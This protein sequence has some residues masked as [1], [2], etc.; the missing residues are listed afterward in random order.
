MRILA[1]YLSEALLHR[2]DVAH[3]CYDD[4]IRQHPDPNVKPPFGWLESGLLSGDDERASPRDFQ[5]E[6][7]K[8]EK[9]GSFRLYLR[10]TYGCHRI[11]MDDLARCANSAAGEWSLCG[12]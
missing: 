9:G 11:P 1:P 2:I 10:F 6:R 12:R 8:T 5:I 4:W 3:A 7:T